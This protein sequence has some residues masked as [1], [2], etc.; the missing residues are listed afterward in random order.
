MVIHKI[1]TEDG[2]CHDGGLTDIYSYRNKWIYGTKVVHRINGP[3]IQCDLP[4]SIYFW[5]V[6]GIEYKSWE[7]FKRHAG[8]TAEDITSLVLKYGDIDA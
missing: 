1:W 3:A 4:S 6:H 5:I 2:M 8:L 7:E